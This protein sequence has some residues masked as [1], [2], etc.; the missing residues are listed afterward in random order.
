M[1]VPKERNNMR[2]KKG[3]AVSIAIPERLY[4][5]LRDLAAEQ[6]RDVNDVLRDAIEWQFTLAGIERQEGKMFVQ[7]GEGSPLRE[8]EGLRM[9]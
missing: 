8:I 1:F 2:K 4:I 6:D 5:A 7:Y 9:R 3:E